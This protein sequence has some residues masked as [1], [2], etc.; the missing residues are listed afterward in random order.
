MT[1]NP[2]SINFYVC[3]PDLGLAQFCA[4]AERAGAQ[5]V[6]LTLRALDEMPVAAIRAL[7]RRHG[8]AVSSLNSAGY[9]LYGDAA[10]ARDQAAR[11]VRLIA[12]AAELEARTLVV[13][14]GG[15]AHGGLALRE[16]RARVV[17]G[18][19]EL[20]RAA[21]ADGVTLGLEMIHPLGI[22]QKGCVN[23][24]SSALALARE[25]DNLGLTLDFFHSWW[26]PDLYTLIETAAHKIALV[27]FCNVAAPDDPAQFVREECGRGLI[28][29]RALLDALHVAG[30]RGHF[31]FEMFPEHLRGRPAAGVIEAAGRFYAAPSAIS[32]KP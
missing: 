12:A 20:A 10:L 28:D 6:G 5:A 3:P 32:V 24:I 21:A 25:H 17:E 2:L 4:L 11:N 8:L 30:Y 29:V 18:I 14:A 16:A 15:I 22:L 9:F 26:D 23:T 19:G 31:E 7:L 1:M 27:Q 13:I